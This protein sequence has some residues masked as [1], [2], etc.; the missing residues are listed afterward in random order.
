MGQIKILW[1]GG[2]ALANEIELTGFLHMSQLLFTHVGGVAR[3]G[4]RVGCAPGV[5]M[6]FLTTSNI[7][8]KMLYIG[9]KK[10][11]LSGAWVII[12]RYFPGLLRRVF[13]TYS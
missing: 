5:L 7:M 6:L 10:D 11:R 4:W 9:D 3:P 8:I 13:L 12:L 2:H 1:I